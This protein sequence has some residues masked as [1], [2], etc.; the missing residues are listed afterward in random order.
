MS[1][2]TEN[3]K[4]ALPIGY[5]LQEYCIQS[6]LG[7]GEFA[8]TYLAQDT[9]L[10]S[11]V[12]L[13]EYFPKELATRENSYNVQH[14]S[15]R[16]EDH[17][18]WGLERFLEEGQKLANFQ[19]PNIVR[20]LRCFEAHY[21]AYLVMEYEFGQSLSSILKRRERSRERLTEA[22]IMTFLPPLLEGLQAVH[23][24]GF[25]HKDIKPDSL[26]LRD[27]NNTPVLLDFGAA[28]YALGSFL[29]R[30]TTIATPGYAPFEQYQKGHQGPWT[31]IY[32]L[33]A[34]LY[35][36]IGGTS[37]PEVLERI[38]TIKRR[39]QPDPLVS[40][41]EMGH[42]QYSKSFLKSIDWALQIA[43]E[44]RPQTVQQ[45]GRSLWLQKPGQKFNLTQLY[46]SIMLTIKQFNRW[47]LG[48]II[49]TI[50][51]S[52]SYVFYTEQSLAE[53]HKKTQELQREQQQS[54]A[55]KTTLQT[56]F[57]TVQG[58]LEEA[59][60]V[61]ETKQQFLTQLQNQHNV[62]QQTLEKKQWQ[63]KK[64]LFLKE[65]RKAAG[66]IIHD[67]EANGYYGPDMVW[68]PTGRFRMGDI[69]GQGESNEQPVHWIT[70]KAFAIGRYEVTFAEYD[71]FANAT[72][73]KKPSDNAWGRGR[74][75]VI[76]VS[77]YDA[78]AYAGWLSQQTGH[79][80]RLPTEAEWEYAVRAGTLTQ[81]WWGDEIDF[82]LA[83]CY[84]CSDQWAG[85]KTTPVGYFAANPFG[86]HDTAGNVREWTCSEYEEKYIGKEQDCMTHTKRF[87][88][89][90]ERGGSWSHQAK[91][92][93]VSSRHKSLPEAH[94]SNV[95]FRLVRED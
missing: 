25:L 77:W 34:V 89:R 87:G 73:R 37:P 92:M 16:Y 12:A 91:E 52:V 60:Q 29:G 69:Q 48:S 94:Y 46:Q 54:A 62:L 83:H 23:E 93:R 71:R 76:N 67:K 85:Q 43:E 74:R 38:D 22:E 32:A 50:G 68:I 10:N 61:I 66:E 84:D 36:A 86:L 26:Y 79:Q 57:E 80:Y 17:F 72:G 49:L 65:K 33:G 20:V 5:Q 11:Q 95:G 30:I 45:W 40:A 39:Y 58:Q 18:A 55:E 59:R 15:Q 75:P 78:T 6:I 13:K 27:K 31:D 47:L 56:A 44:D 90:V 70:I 7:K 82:K 24:A 3:I 21:T 4:N 81:Y 14:K 35:R 28:R 53:L 1:V 2:V 64:T 8:I 42:K 19:H 63:L 41:I 88:Y 51:L 9:K